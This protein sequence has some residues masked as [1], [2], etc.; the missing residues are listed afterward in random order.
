MWEIGIDV[1]SLVLDFIGS[2][3]EVEVEYSF[4]AQGWVRKLR[5][6]C[7]LRSVKQAEGRVL[8]I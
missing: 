4:L 8:D 6:S 7:F 1:M 2:K 5:W 3:P